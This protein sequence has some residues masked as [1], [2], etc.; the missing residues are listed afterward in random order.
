MRVSESKEEHQNQS[1]PHVEKKKE[2]RELSC[3]VDWGWIG[4]EFS[5]LKCQWLWFEWW[6]WG[7]DRHGESRV[8]KIL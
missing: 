6:G 4:L 7:F 2:K 8:S 1:S 3:C 5:S